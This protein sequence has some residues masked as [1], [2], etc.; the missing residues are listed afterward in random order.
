MRRR[1]RSPNVSMISGVM[2]FDPP[3]DWRSISKISELS[4]AIRFR[5][6]SISAFIT[7]S[8][9]PSIAAATHRSF[10]YNAYQSGSE[11]IGGTGTQSASGRCSSVAGH[12]FEINIVDHAHNARLGIVDRELLLDLLTRRSASTVM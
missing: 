2:R 8:M 7:L 6:M 5:T 12:I 4:D 9:P 10:A 1:S 11:M 3:L